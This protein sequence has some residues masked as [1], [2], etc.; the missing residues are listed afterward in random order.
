MAYEQ[1]EMCGVLFRNDR[2]TQDNHPD[3]NGSCTING[4]EY[5]ISAWVKEGQRGKFFSMAFKPKL[6]NQKRA[7]DALRKGADAAKPS[8]PE[9][10][11]SNVPF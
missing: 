11:D 4:V 3:H 1:K 10:D 7:V 5:W 8:N 9:P 6:D 2:K